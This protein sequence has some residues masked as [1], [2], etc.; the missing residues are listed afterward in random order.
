MVASAMFLSTPPSRVATRSSRRPRPSLKVS[1]H[2]TLAG[3]DA[4]E[5]NPKSDVISVSI[6]ATLA[7]GD[8]HAS[9]ACTTASHV[10]IH[11]TLAGGDYASASAVVFAGVFLSTPPSRVA[12]HRF[13]ISLFA[14][15]CFYPRHPRGWRPTTM[16]IMN[17]LTAFLSTPPSRV[18]TH[19]FVLHSMLELLFLSTPPSRVA[20]KNPEAFGLKFDCFYPRHPRGWRHRR[21]HLVPLAPCF[22]P[23]HPRGWRPSVAFHCHL[24]VQVSIHATLAGGDQRQRQMR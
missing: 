3:G 15:E 5:I 9:N 17:L 12:T 11:A 21:I 2:A 10:S 4:V 20:T 8:I 7:G 19:F 24:I 1:I 22:Y 16:G 23:R 14:L 6:H 18:A 13:P